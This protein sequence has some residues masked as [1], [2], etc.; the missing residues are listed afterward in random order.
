MDTYDTTSLQALES[1]IND[2]QVDE[3][4]KLELLQSYNFSL[5]LLE[6]SR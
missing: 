4:F 5:G 6:S 2:D 3:S 1:I